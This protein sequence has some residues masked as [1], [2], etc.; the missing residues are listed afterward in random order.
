MVDPLKFPL[1]ETFAGK[2]WD[3]LTWTVSAVEAEE[4]EYDAALTSARFQFQDADGAVALTLSS[5]TAGQV[6]INTATANAWSIT[7]EPRILT[8]TAGTYTYGLE[9]TDADG[10]EKPRMA[11]TIVIKPD[12]VV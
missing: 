2:T 6:T 11:G 9:T 5:A 10:R 7:V 1:P 3:G 12:P 8:L 4:T